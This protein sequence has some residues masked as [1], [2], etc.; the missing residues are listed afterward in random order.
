MEEH[1]LKVY[2]PHILTVVIVF[3]T[4]IITF[5]IMGVNFSPYKDKQI[6]KY[7]QNP[8]IPTPPD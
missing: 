3:F 7:K 6:Q 1:F 2:W 4:L 5:E 8:K